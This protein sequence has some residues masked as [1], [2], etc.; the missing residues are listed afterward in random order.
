MAPQAIKSYIL[1]QF[2]LFG[3]TSCV[4]CSVLI[5]VTVSLSFSSGHNS[6][7][8][9][10]PGQ[11]SNPR[12]CSNLSHCSQILNPLHHSRNSL[13]FKKTKTKTKIKFI[14]CTLLIGMQKFLGQGLNPCHSSDNTKSLTTRPPGNSCDHLLTNYWLLFILLHQQMHLKN[15]QYG[16]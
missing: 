9:K 10:F 16:L 6:S 12:L 14:L 2:Q 1:S 11:G 5:T 13:F 3:Y 8:R 4:T 15:I 7:L